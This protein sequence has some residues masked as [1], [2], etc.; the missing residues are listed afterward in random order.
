MAALN[1][2]LYPHPIDAFVANFIATFIDFPG[3]GFP[4]ANSQSPIPNR[5]SRNPQSSILNPPQSGI[6]C[7]RRF[8][9]TRGWDVGLCCNSAVRDA[10]APN[11]P[12]G[13]GH[14]SRHRIARSVVEATSQREA[15]RGT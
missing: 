9:K 15:G 5:Q 1:L 10:G 14:T 3:H 8:R 13:G 2:S 12:K 4:I 7:P 6:P 11:I